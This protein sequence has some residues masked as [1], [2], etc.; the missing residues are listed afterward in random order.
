MRES[1]VPPELIYQKFQRTRYPSP[2]FDIASIALNLPLKDLQKFCF[3]LSIIDPIIGPLIRKLAR[4]AITQ[5]LVDCEDQELKRYYEQLI[6]KIDLQNHLIQIGL[7]FHTYGNAFVTIFYPFTRT[8]RCTSCKILH[9]ISDL[10]KRGQLEYDKKLNLLT[11]FAFC[12]TCRGR[13][14]IIIE[15]NIQTDLPI[16]KFNNETKIVH[17]APQQ[18][19]IEYIPSANV[20]VYTYILTKQEEKMISELNENALMYMHENFLKAYITKTKIRLLNIF[21][22]KYPTPTDPQFYPGWGISPIVNVM[23]LIYYGQILRKAN[24]VI[25]WEHILPLRI[26]TLSREAPPIDTS[27]IQAT[28]NEL[29]KKWRQDPGMIA[30]LP[31]PL[32]LRYIGGEGKALLLTGEIANVVEQIITGME[33]PRELVYGGLGWSSS[34]VALRM[35]EN[36]FMNYI[37]QLQHFLSYFNEHIKKIYNISKDVTLRFKTFRRADD[38]NYL[39]LLINLTQAQL[40]SKETLLDILGFDDEIEKQKLKKELK[41]FIDTQEELAKYDKEKKIQIV[42]ELANQII[43]QWLSRAAEQT[44]TTIIDIERLIDNWTFQLLQTPADEREAILKNLKQNMPDVYEAIITKLLGLQEALGGEI[45]PII[46]QMH[47]NI[48]TE[49]IEPLPE[50]KPPRRKKEVI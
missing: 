1:D 46:S 9:N 31:Y 28:L 37:Y 14:K 20:S 8:F 35:L 23:K 48:K 19:D 4:Y 42:N 49:N 29:I 22:F 36:Y 30:V 50:K 18:I 43:S 44:G 16:G 47:T 45:E 26:L 39:S 40:I 13:R 6:D 32:E 24:E 3:I 41:E 38:I 17:W 12:P 34:L 27:A 11:F 7:D 33:V 5:I 2:F 10:T 21:H 15:T 25:A